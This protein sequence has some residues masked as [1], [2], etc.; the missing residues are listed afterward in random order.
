MA[1][2]TKRALNLVSGESILSRLPLCVEISLKTIEGDSMVLEVWYLGLAP[3]RCDPTQRASYTVY[4]RMAILLKSLISI[5]RSTPAYKL[6]RRQ[7]TDSYQILYRVYVGDPDTHSLGKFLF[8][9][10]PFVYFNWNFRNRFAIVFKY[11]IFFEI[12]S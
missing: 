4:N 5:T 2:E 11:L 12:S 9:N 7:S 10:F 1:E 6:S 3:D 8:F